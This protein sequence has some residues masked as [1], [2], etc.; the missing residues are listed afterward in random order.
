MEYF[1]DESFLDKFN[2]LWE[3]GFWDNLLKWFQEQ[4]E[5]NIEESQ[6][7]CFVEL[8]LEFDQAYRKLESD[9]RELP[10]IMNCRTKGDSTSN[11]GG[12][13]CARFASSIR[14]SAEKYI[15]HS[16]CS[17]GKGV[18]GFIV[19]IRDKARQNE[20]FAWEFEKKAKEN[21]S[22]LGVDNSLKIFEKSGSE[23]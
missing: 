4:T 10:M 5:N 21:Y 9:I 12:K 6:E 14:K 23:M 7:R 2:Y 3:K 17:N 11:F 19:K 20:E 1:S 22:V 18:K 8:K 13:Q 16:A 15:K